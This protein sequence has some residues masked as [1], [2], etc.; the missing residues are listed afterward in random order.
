MSRSL[1]GGGTA[2]MPVDPGDVLS[3]AWWAR[4]DPG[5]GPTP[6]LDWTWYNAGGGVIS[7]NNGSAQTANATWGRKLQENIV[8][9]ALAEFVQFRLAWTGTALVDQVLEFAQ[10][11]INE[12]A[13]STAP[14]QIEAVGTLCVFPVFTLTNDLTAPIVITY[15]PPQFTYNEDIRSEERRVGK[16]CV[17]TCS[18]RW[19]PYHKKKNKKK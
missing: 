10:V 4:K 3:V 13:T 11:W 14:D 7:S 2:A 5:G 19:S 16:E 17:S 8:A 15:G 1:S 6:R 9:P 12:G 18:S